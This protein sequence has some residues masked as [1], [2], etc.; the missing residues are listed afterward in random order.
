MKNGDDVPL[1]KSLFLDLFSI[2]NVQ[3]PTPTF[4]EKVVQKMVG[5]QLMRTLEEV[6]Y[7]NPFQSGF[8]PG[9]SIV[10][11]PWQNQDGGPFAP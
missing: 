4:L 8:R 9:L 3:S 10:D 2:N 5:V 6:D 1:L 7:L 11:N